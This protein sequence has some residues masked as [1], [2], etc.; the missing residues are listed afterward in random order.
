MAQMTQ[1]RFALD[2]LIISL[3]DYLIG[4]WAC[5]SQEPRVALSARTPRSFVAAGYPLQSL[6]RRT[7]E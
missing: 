3:S 1:M 6:T 5:P 4:I 2:H 7:I